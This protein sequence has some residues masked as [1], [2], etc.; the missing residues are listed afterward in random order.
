MSQ[1]AGWRNGALTIVPRGGRKLRHAGLLLVLLSSGGSAVLAEVPPDR[2]LA[3]TAGSSIQN[4]PPQVGMVYPPG[5]DCHQRVRADFPPPFRPP[6]EMGPL[7]RQQLLIAVQPDSDPR[8]ADVSR[9]SSAGIDTLTIAP[10][11]GNGSAPGT[12]VFGEECTVYPPIRHPGRPGYSFIYSVPLARAASDPDATRLAEGES[13]PAAPSRFAGSVDN[14]KGLMIGSQPE[15]VPEAPEQDPGAANMPRLVV[16]P[17]WIEAGALV[18]DEARAAG[19]HYLH[20]TLAME[21]LYSDN[22]EARLGGRVDGYMQRG[23]ADF[24]KSELDYAES[25]LRYRNADR[26]VTLGAQTVLW[27]RV[28]ELPPTDRLSVQDVSRFVLDDLEDRR[29]AV[30]AVRWEEFVGAHKL[31]LLYVPQFRAA[32]RPQEESIWSPVD[33]DRGRLIGMPANP[34]LAPLVTG[35]RF[36]EDDD[37]RGGWGLRL[38]RAG[39]NLDYG[40]TVQD[41]RH[42]LPY[43]ELAPAV[44]SSLLANS[45]DVEGALAA[46][47]DTFTARHPRTWVVGGDLAFSAGRSTWRLEAAWLSDQPATTEDLRYTTVEALDWV[48][49]VEFFPGDRNL[50]MTAQLRGLHLLNAKDELLDRETIYTLFGDIENSFE[51]ERWRVRLRY[52][53]GLDEHDVYL[54]PELAFQGRE[55]HE[56]YLG[57]HYFDGAPNTPGGFHRHH[58]L[59]TLGWRAR[60]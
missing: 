11:A 22:W 36:A 50:R 6:G 37:G 46:A 40:L 27:G 42:S 58:D 60:F 2:A 43:Y 21:W 51:R 41:A 5:A 57:F 48:A 12:G 53:I 3:G 25:Y 1:D 13:V 7:Q 19:S 52:S 28:D 38:S 30:P 24:E 33:R 15:P 32:E 59:F 34:L 55:P 20:S 29:R 56:L 35:G 39:H 47:P 23:D 45:S 16:D 4:P 10:G 8:W 31:D 44:R 54:N 26:T 49:G 9:Q 17:I 14:S 18:D